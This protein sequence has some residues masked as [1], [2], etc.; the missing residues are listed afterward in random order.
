MSH[1]KV[2]VTDFDG[3]ITK[4]DFYL[5]AIQR[6]IPSDC[7]NHWDEYRC[8]RLTHFDA[9]AEYFRAIRKDESEVFEVLRE[10]QIDENLSCSV[11]SL[12]QQGWHIV[13]TSAGCQWYIDQLLSDAGVELEVHAN[14][15]TYSTATGLEMKRPVSSEFL[16]HEIGIDKP[17][18]V[19]HWCKQAQTVAFAGDGYP[20]AEA[21]KLV[22]NE[23]RFARGDLAQQLTDENISFR[24]FAN[25]SEI[26]TALL[27][28]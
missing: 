7:P 28:V 15:G 18:V 3:T 17:A 27:D 23:L 16:S 11:S 9:L 12:R 14:P 19:R 1:E 5:L 26:A 22:P 4:H 25:W 6:L 10:M 13:V 2:F 24:P 21:A 8:G 20:D